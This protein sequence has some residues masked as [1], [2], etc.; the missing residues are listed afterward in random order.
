MQRDFIDLD[1]AAGRRVAGNPDHKESVTPRFPGFHLQV[2]G[3]FHELIV[4]QS[5]ILVGLLNDKIPVLM[6]F[7]SKRAGQRMEFRMKPDTPRAVMPGSRVVTLHRLK[8]LGHRVLVANPRKVSAICQNVRKSDR[9]DS[10]LLARIARADA[11][12]RYPV[13]HVS[14]DMQRDLRPGCCGVW[15]LRVRV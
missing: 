5:Q 9:N 13:E 10:E 2:E 4:L 7:D 8:E 14:E 1:L 12:L 11:K 6:D 15:G 3:E